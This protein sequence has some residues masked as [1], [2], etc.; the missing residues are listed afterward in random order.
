V[1][2]ALVNELQDLDLRVWGQLG[3]K[4]ARIDCCAETA[5]P[6]IWEGHPTPQG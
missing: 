1:T 6:R 3:V 4:G 2:D 5:A